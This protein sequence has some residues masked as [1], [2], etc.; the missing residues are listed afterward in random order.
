MSGEPGEPQ[1]ALHLSI[2]NAITL[3]ILP[4]LDAIRVCYFYAGLPLH[5]L[6]H[7]W[8]LWR[9]GM[10]IFAAAML[11]TFC[12]TPLYATLGPWI[13]A[14]F[15]AMNLL[16]TL[17]MVL[18]PNL[19]PAVI[20]GLFGAATTYFLD[21]Y[22]SMNFARFD[23]P[24]VRRRSSR[25]IT[26]GDTV[27]YAISPFIC[28]VLY[29]LGAWQLCAFFQLGICVVELLLVWTNPSIASDWR[30]WQGKRRLD[31]SQQP[32]ADAKPRSCPCRCQGDAS[33]FL[34]PEVRW[35]AIAI[36]V[37]S[38]LNIFLYVTEW[39]LFAVYFR[40]VF[41]WTSAFWAGAAQMAGDIIGA[42]ILVLIPKIKP[43]VKCLRCSGSASCPLF[44]APY[45]LS[46]LLI[47]WA[48][49]H[50]GLAS[51]IFV[52]AVVAQVAMGTVFVFCCQ[53]IAEMNQLYA[54]GDF[55]IHLRLQCLSG[56]C[57]GLGVAVG[58]L[59]ALWL[60]EQVAKI[61]PFF[62]ATAL[63]LFG[64]AFYT[65][66]FCARVGLPSSPLAECEA[67]AVQDVQLVKVVPTETPPSAAEG[68]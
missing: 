53:A 56:S 24:E 13:V 26:L 1:A 41:N 34:P 40:Q 29:D 47:A 27:G 8:A 4:G 42:L 59:V 43:F 20:V 12:V 65:T 68:A 14:P 28:G 62:V 49:L 37:T 57:F 23:D 61:A 64:C 55:S 18:W 7:G 45:H 33:A 58:G 46:A 9:L 36:A 6:E 54:G 30:R 50:V 16:A 31:D 2:N 19:E 63:A 44:A 60:Y 11:R 3:V 35:P 38:G 52:I 32:D 21:A 51:P 17:P 15:T 25:F 5:F 10:C 22:H 67:R 48:V 39:S 66:I